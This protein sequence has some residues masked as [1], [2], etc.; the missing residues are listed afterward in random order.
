MSKFQK[1]LLEKGLEPTKSYESDP[2]LSNKNL[3]QSAVKFSQS[4]PSFDQI[5]NDTSIFDIKVVIGERLWWAFHDSQQW[6]GVVMAVNTMYN[7]M[8]GSSVSKSYLFPNN[9]DKGTAI[10]TDHADREYEVDMAEF[11]S[12][13]KMCY[14][15]NVRFQLNEEQRELY[16]DFIESDVKMYSIL[17]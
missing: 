5:M 6:E 10:V 15:S 8:M 17:N 7:E 3:N 12:I 13:I 16:Y 11:F 14:L 1:V 2:K 4:L 9:S